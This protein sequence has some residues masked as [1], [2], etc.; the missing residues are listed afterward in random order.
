MSDEEPAMLT[1]DLFSVSDQVVLVSGG[2]RGIGR[3]IA[4]GFAQRGAQVVITGREEKPLAATAAEISAAGPAVRGLVCDVAD[5]A[6]VKRLTE[7]A[8]AELGH[9]DTLINVAGVN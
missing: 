9:I 1:D 5:A 4:Q 2:S 6:A 7:Q 3:A 8:V